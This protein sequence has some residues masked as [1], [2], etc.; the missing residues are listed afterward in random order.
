[1][2]ERDRETRGEGGRDKRTILLLSTHPVKLC[3][4]LFQL[5]CYLC[6]NISL[7]INHQ[8]L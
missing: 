5:I 4:I 6:N 2:L 1:M 3:I 7:L 8:K